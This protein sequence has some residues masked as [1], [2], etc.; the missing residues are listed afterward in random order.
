MV[1]VLSFSHFSQGQM[2]L[3]EK[4]SMSDTVL[5]QEGN[6]QSVVVKLDQPTRILKVM[7]EIEIL[8]KISFCKTR[9]SCD[10]NNVRNKQKIYL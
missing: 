10:Q 7:V 3:R 5:Q 9:K 6:P 4:V 1:V 8:S 2:I